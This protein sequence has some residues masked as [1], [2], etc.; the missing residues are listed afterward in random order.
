MARSEARVSTELWAPGGDFVQLSWGAQWLYLF[1]IS[2]P[3]LAHTGVLPL[4]ARRWSRSA[5]DLSP[6]D[7]EARLKELEDARFVIVDYDTEELLIRSFVRRDRVYKQP[8]VLRAARDH[9]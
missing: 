7:I 8:N 4:R 5:S 3:D 6:A 2:Q 1:L 9:L